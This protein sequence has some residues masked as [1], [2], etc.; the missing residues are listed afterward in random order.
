[1][2]DILLAGFRIYFCFT[3]LTTSETTLAAS[4][5]YAISA[6]A[7]SSESPGRELGES[8]GQT[9]FHIQSQSLECKPLQLS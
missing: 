4:S 2:V 6:S 9:N 1:M 8:F 7:S 5:R 3:W